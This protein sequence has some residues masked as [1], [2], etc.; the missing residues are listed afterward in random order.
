M[1][2]QIEWPWM[3]GQLD[4]WCSFIWF[5]I[6]CKFYDFHLNSYRNRN[7]LRI[8]LYKYIRNQTG[9]ALKKDK[10]QPRFIICANRVGPTF[11]MQHN[12]SQGHWPFGSREGDFKGVL[13]YMDMVAILVMGSLI[14]AIKLLLSTYGVF[15]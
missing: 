10:G 15:I 5:N 14:F 1:A 13:P 3:T 4:L 9:I 6:S 2:V 12:K 11:P 7:I 8:F